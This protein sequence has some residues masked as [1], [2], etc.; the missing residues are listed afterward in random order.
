MLFHAF[1]FSTP[2]LP[3]ILSLL[4]S[5]IL[6]QSRDLISPLPLLHLQFLLS[7]PLL[8]P[9]WS[10][11]QIP[12]LAVLWLFPCLRLSL[13]F[14]LL[15]RRFILHLQKNS[16]HLRPPQSKSSWISRPPPLFQWLF[17]QEYSPFF[18]SADVFLSLYDH[19]IFSLSSKVC[20]KLL[21]YSALFGWHINSRK[22]L[23]RIVSYQR[24]RG[25]F[26]CKA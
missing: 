1:P 23:F 7:F 26:C 20:S 24:R 9:L 6:S 15:F 16:S 10:P 17:L 25:P 8:F 13:F 14:L 4:S 18:P 3:L 11:Q 2:S 22:W 12:F 5:P 21:S 19:G